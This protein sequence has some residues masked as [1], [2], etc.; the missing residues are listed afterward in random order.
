M[1]RRQVLGLGAA[2]AAAAALAACSRTRSTSAGTGTPVERPDPGSRRRVVVVGAGLAG[3]TAALDLA[4]AGWDVVVLEARRRVGGRVHT[5]RAPFSTGL[6]AEAGG[7]SIDDGHHALLAMVGRFGLRTERRTPDKILR[8]TTSWHG[9]RSATADFVSPPAVATDYARFTAALQQLTQGLDPTHPERA[10]QAESLDRRS[11]ASFIDSL[12]LDPRARFLV[13]SDVRGGFNAQ[14]HDVSLLFAA[15][16]AVVSANA[17]DATVETM[18]ISGGNDRLPTAMAAALGARVVTGAPVTRIEHRV[19][20]VTVR[21]GDHV[22][23]GS[24]VV[25]ACPVQTL[26]RVTFAPALPASVAAVVDGLDLGHAAKVTVEYRSRFWERQHRSGFTLTDL[27]IGI[28][29]APTDSYASTAGL[30]SAFITGDAAVAAGR[31]PD[32]ARIA[33]VQAQLDRIYPEGAPE[34]AGP[35]ATTAWANEPF[36]GGGYAV[37]KPGQMVPFWPILQAGSGRIRFAGEHTETLA[38]YMES[39]VRSGHRVATALGP[40]PR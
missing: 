39:A 5:V 12:H 25:L 16:Q 20:G 13:E 8:G 9:T 30:L 7:E 18:R 1:S 28:A 15:Q 11:V 21:A 4:A 29:W 10:G 2:G 33:D 40:P 37:F 6:H 32:A 22:V 31:Q 34:H 35:A 14:P 24:W 38:G 27:P 36:T 19:D 23:H 3:L 26:R 17:A